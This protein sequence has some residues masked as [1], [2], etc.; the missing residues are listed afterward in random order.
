MSLHSSR[1][2]SFNNK[3]QHVKVHRPS[4]YVGLLT[5]LLTG[6]LSQLCVLYNEIYVPTLSR[7]FLIG[8]QPD[9]CWG[10]SPK[11]QHVM[12]QY[13]HIYFLIGRG[14]VMGWM[15]ICMRVRVWFVLVW[16]LVSSLFLSVR[17]LQAQGEW[18][19]GPALVHLVPSLE[20]PN[21]Q[22]PTD[23][24]TLTLNVL[25]SNDRCKHMNIHTPL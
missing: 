7:S 23:T 2:P 19:R 1:T 25:P 17:W 15:L 14:R 21:T 10:L 3:S 4:Q 11:Q 9:L 20:A 16:A 12:M 5:T 24:T 6:P 13:K 8:C 22:R 18:W